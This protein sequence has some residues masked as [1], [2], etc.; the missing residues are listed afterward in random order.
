MEPQGHFVPSYPVPTHPTGLSLKCLGRV[1]LLEA[2]L[3]RSAMPGAGVS[4]LEWARE[5]LRPQGLNSPHLIPR[6]F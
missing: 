6:A 1:L 3:I 5:G 4:H 2:G